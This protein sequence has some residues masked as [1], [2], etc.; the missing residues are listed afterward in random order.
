MKYIGI[1]GHRGVGKKSFAVLLSN[2][3]DTICQHGENS[4]AEFD[5][6]WDGWVDEIMANP[7]IIPEDLMETKYTYVDSFGDIP[8]TF[9]SLMLGIDS[10]LLDNNEYKDTHAVNLKDLSVCLLSDVTGNI[11]NDSDMYRH[12][13]AG[14]R[15]VIGTDAYITVRNF[16][17]Y[18][19]I[20][21]MQQYF[22]KHVWINVLKANASLFNNIFDEDTSYKIYYD[23]KTSSELDYIDSLNGLIIN[24]IRPENKKRRG[25]EDLHEDDRCDFQVTIEGD[26][27][28]T[29][30]D[31]WGIANEI[32]NKYYMSNNE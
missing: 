2:T 19:G 23:V 15:Q 30:E 18:F 3:I 14:N 29:K 11:Y 12:F 1:R 32:V 5:S 7:D 17:T 31:I 26:L 10:Y 6:H 24:L 25:V 16:I 4:R 13:N 22:G 8:K 20:Q 9:I 28:S 21:V 27:N